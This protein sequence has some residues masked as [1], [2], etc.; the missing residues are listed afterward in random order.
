LDH[1]AK[2]GL[3]TPYPPADNAISVAMIL[4]GEIEEDTRDP[5]KNKRSIDGATGRAAQRDKLS[6][7]RR[8]RLPERPPRSAGQSNGRPERD[9]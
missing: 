1:K 2:N 5:G 8:R 6:P 3:P 7:G 9:V 4:T